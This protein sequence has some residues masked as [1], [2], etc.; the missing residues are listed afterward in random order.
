MVGAIE[1]LAWR[2]VAAVDGVNAGEAV[3]VRERVVT[4]PVMPSTAASCA[5]ALSM[6]EVGGMRGFP[7]GAEGMDGVVGGAGGGGRRWEDTFWGGAGQ[8]PA[9]APAG[10]AGRIFFFSSR[11]PQA[12]TYVACAVVAAATAPPRATSP[13]P[14][15]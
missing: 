2:S 12:S 13:T 8:V 1:V 15:G 10:D 9:V 5:D 7:G 11:T 3:A 14:T 6:A 4:V